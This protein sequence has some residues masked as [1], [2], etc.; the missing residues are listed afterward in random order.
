LQNRYSK[1]SEIICV[2][3]SV[4]QHGL[5]F[6]KKCHNCLYNPPISKGHPTFFF[7]F[8]APREENKFQVTDL[9][10]GYKNAYRC[11][12]G[13]CV[14]LQHLLDGREGLVGEVVEREVERQHRFVGRLQS[15]HLWSLVL[16]ELIHRIANL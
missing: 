10:M 3:S 6:K 2:S 13:L 9:W 1:Y 8:F 14:A 5:F 4:L 16:G 11:L 12:E 7:F 15:C